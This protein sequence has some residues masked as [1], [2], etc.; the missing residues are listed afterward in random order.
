MPLITR[1]EDLIKSE[2]SALLDK[3]QSSE[4]THR[5]IKEELVQTLADCRATAAAL[6]YEQKTLRK[7]ISKSQ[8]QA[9]VW[10]EKAEHA[11]S[12]S[13]DDLAKSAL[14]HKHTELAQQTD[15]QAQLDKIT[16]ML[17]KLH[18]DADRL[19]AKINVLNNK[20]LQLGRREQVAA[21]Q[22]KVRQTLASN[23]IDAALTRF[24]YLE[25]KVER[26]ESE[27]ASY[28]LGEPNLQ[29]EFAALEAEDKLANELACLKAKVNATPS[30][31]NAS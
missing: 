28:E 14:I 31:H 6:I 23:N 1:I 19:K 18:T 16:P 24:E 5:Y 15:L 21:T 22:L 4:A 10:Q 30:Q 11:L 12:K 25:Q 27:L 20:E 2:V 3:A 7:Q 8:A 13:R 17:E 9:D 29:A 26:L